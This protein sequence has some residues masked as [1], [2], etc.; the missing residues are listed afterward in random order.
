MAFTQTDLGNNVRALRNALQLTQ[1]NLSETAN[2]SLKHLGEIER[3]RGNPTLTT[4]V[5]LAGALNVPLPELVAA[6]GEG[7]EIDSVTAELRVIIQQASHSD[8]ATMLR[9][10]KALQ[11]VD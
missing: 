1:E 5:A 6:K 4:L 7:Q 11:D 9:V 2:I 8:R 3:G 10:V